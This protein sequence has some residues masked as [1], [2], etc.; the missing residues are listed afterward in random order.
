VSDNT[1]P[2]FQEA[3]TRDTFKVCDVDLTEKGLAF[4]GTPKAIDACTDVDVKFSGVTV[5]NNG[6]VCDTTSVN[7]NWTASDKNGNIST[8]TKNVVFFRADT[9]DLILAKNTT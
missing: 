3:S 6:G 9:S 5:L 4:L 2:I 1:A 8:F 7:V